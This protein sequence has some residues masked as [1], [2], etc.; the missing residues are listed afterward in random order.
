MSCECEANAADDAAPEGEGL[1]DVR[2]LMLSRHRFATAWVRDTVLTAKRVDGVSSIDMDLHADRGG[3]RRIGH[4]LFRNTQ[5]PSNP[6]SATNA[7]SS[8]QIESAAS[9][10]K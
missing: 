2:L 3:G 6:A 4:Y 8:G 10:V 5:N 9:H 7:H 1:R